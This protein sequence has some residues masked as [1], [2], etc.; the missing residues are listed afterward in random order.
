MNYDQ[1]S[2]SHADKA[3]V[4]DNCAWYRPF[5]ASGSLVPHIAI[6]LERIRF[7]CPF[8]IEDCNGHARV[9]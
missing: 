5:A 3:G 2:I 8:T 9:K 1:A 6:R 4:G 7:I